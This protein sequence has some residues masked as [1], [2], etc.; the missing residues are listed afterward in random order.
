MAK[1]PKTAIWK[2]KP[3]IKDS[4]QDLYSTSFPPC[5]AIA[6]LGC[7]SGPNTLLVVS[8]IINTIN[9]TC[10]RLSRPSP[11]VQVFLNDL[12]GN[13]FNTIFR[14]LPAFY[15]K[16]KRE[17]GPEFKGYFIVGTPGSFYERL[18]PTTSLYFVHSSYGVHWLSQ[19]PPGLDDSETGVALNKGN[20]YIVESSPPNV[21]NAYKE[22]FQRDFSL[23]LKL[24]SQEMVPG[25]RMVLTVM[26]RTCIDPWNKEN[27]T[28]WE[29]L[30]MS[31]S[32]M[33]LEGLIEE[34]KLDSFNLP[35][36]TPS[37]HEIKDLIQMEGSF[38]LDRME[39][40]KLS[41]DPTLT[42]DDGINKNKDQLLVYDKFKSAQNVTKMIRAVAEPMILNHFGEEMLDDLFQRYMEKVAE[43][44]GREES[45]YVNLVVSMIKE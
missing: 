40:F 19:V 23:F 30:S 37:T 28:T 8:E 39:I 26:G 34:A 9:N 32:D 12:P 42:E 33:V 5:V 38:K 6:D 20:I 3:I 22:Q 10:R 4:I 44:L 41:W 11:E 29:L 36:Y 7:S 27:C 2:A 1:N 31:L 15:D 35:Y 25:G 45:K 24:R 13:D 14:S 21:L 17:K 18:F 43:Y 16:L